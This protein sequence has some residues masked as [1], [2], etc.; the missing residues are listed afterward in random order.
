MPAVNESPRGPTGPDAP[1]TWWRYARRSR[2]LV[3]LSA[4]CVA[5]ALAFT[6]SL[7]AI[8][9]G[10]STQKRG[11]ALTLKEV[12]GGV[13]YYAKF[14]HAL[15]SG[16]SYFPLGVWIESV[17]SQAD[18]DKDKDAGLNLYVS[19]TANSNLSLVHSN[20]MQVIL[21]EDEWR[22]NAAARSNPAVAGW[23]L[24]D[25]IDMCCGPPGFDGGNGYHMLD[26]ILA[27]LPQDGRARYNNYG[28]G[29]LLW[30]GDAQAAQFVNDYQQ[31]VSAD[32]YWFTDPNQIDMV[33]QSWLPEGERQMTLA[34]V[35]RAANYGYLIDRMRGL[36]SPARS[37]PVWAVVEVGWPFTETAAQGGRAINPSEVRAAVWHSIIAGARGIIYFNHSFGG[38]CPTQHV[39][40]DPCYADVRATVK[41]VNTQIK[42]LAP[43]LNAPFVTSGWTGGSGTNAMVKWQGGHLYVFAGSAQGPAT[44]QFSIP[45]VGDASATVL[46]EDREIPVTS[47]SFSDSFAG[48]NAIHIYRID[49]G[50]ACGLPT[51]RPNT[52]IT[53]GPNGRSKDRTP[54]FRFESDQTGV[55][56]ECRIGSKPFRDC[57][58]PF[59]ADRLSLGVHRF[60][61]RASNV[62]GPDQTP[63]KRSF[64]VVKEP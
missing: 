18:I 23:G 29:V 16:E 27:S 11:L 42:S 36:I 15:P 51:A 40:R 1:S 50:S 3:L 17:S 43:V 33:G 48:G 14:S 49:G 59:T 39:L 47:G 30:E 38:P 6:V 7:A 24:Y 25:E 28:K 32:L 46:G 21:Q 61:A 52:T 44:G 64:K 58:S 12:D 37:K 41:D 19:I 26:D 22:N 4:C 13:D 34:E 63:A 56:F 55:S 5:V 54:T 53:S 31:F 20:G 60:R 45:C 57:D 10:G 9:T 35:R 62:Y 2:T 8:P